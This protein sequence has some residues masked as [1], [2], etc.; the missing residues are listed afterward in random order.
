MTSQTAGPDYDVAIIGGGISG[1]YTGWRLLTA[2]AASSPSLRSWAG[3]RGN[4]LKVGVFEGSQRIGGRLLSAQPPGM[5]N[6]ICEIGGM[7]YVSSQTY[8]RSLIE[9]ELKL[10]RR[11]QV[12]DLP[13][14]LA[15]LRG[16][17]LRDSQLNTPAL[18]PYDLDWT[19]SQWLSTP[20]GAPSGLIAW[21]LTKI[22][23]QIQSLSG[24][25][26]RNFLQQAEVEGVPL[27]QHG[28][29]NVLSRVM[30]PEAYQL[31]RTMV[32]YDCLG[33][34]GNAVDLTIC[35]FDFTPNVH[36]YLLNEGYETV[37]WLL[38]QRFKNAGGDVILGRWLDS[39]DAATLPDGSTGFRLQFREGEHAVTARA[40]VLAM[41]RAA[42]ERLRPEGAVLD[43]QKAPQF[44]AMMQAVKSI[45]LYKLFIGYPYPWW[46]QAGV[47]EGRSLTDIP[48]RQCYYWA[49]NSTLQ[50]G[51]RDTNAIAMVYDDAANV[52][53]WGGLRGTMGRGRAHIRDHQDPVALFQGQSTAASATAAP[54]QPFVDRLRRNWHEHKAP[55][56]MVNEIHRQLMLMHDVRYA[57][58]PTE[59]AFMDWSEEPFGAGVHLWNRGYKSWVIVNEMTQPVKDL[60][61]YVCGEAYST[62]QTWAEGALET[63]EI[64]LQKRFHLAA[65]PWVTQDPVPPATAQA[66]A[67]VT[68]GSNSTNGA[69]G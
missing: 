38:E 5:P 44:R 12:V 17:R 4:H 15:Y 2:D 53:F 54:G 61:C 55:Q 59:A 33:N 1:I 3:A 35:Y 40:V 56:A 10:P 30:S 49:A 18:L 9:N 43:P 25:E 57:P 16:A 68:V 58:E 47:S 65:P 46:T 13:E 26:L 24:T 27:Y 69:G 64:V 50:G 32:G 63:A 48:L 7:R 66:A 11:E 45:P 60:P 29:W 51:P 37:P 22:L 67:P 41:P 20:A 31:C 34:N 6:V 36:Y 62:S 23:P 39:F 14:N 8:V 52:D 28:F 21:S 19:E 42:L